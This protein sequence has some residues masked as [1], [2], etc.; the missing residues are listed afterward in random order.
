[1]FICLYMVIFHEIW[2]KIH[3]NLMQH[4]LKIGGTNYNLKW[5]KVPGTVPYWKAYYLSAEI[6][7]NEHQNTKFIDIVSGI[8][9]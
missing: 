7:K 8:L 4:S 3:E 2:K 6:N 5:V 1:M 9:L